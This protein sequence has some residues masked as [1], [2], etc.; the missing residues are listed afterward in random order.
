MLAVGSMREPVERLAEGSKV[1]FAR[2]TVTVSRARARLRGAAVMRS[3]VSDSCAICYILLHV[4]NFYYRDDDH[5]I[6]KEPS[7][8]ANGVT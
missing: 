6:L 4:I 5:R 3:Y 1:G 7:A 8:A 2:A